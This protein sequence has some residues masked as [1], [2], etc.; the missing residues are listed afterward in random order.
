MPDEPRSQPEPARRAPPTTPGE[1]IA[2]NRVAWPT[3]IGTLGF[4]LALLSG[5]SSIWG[6]IESVLGYDKWYAGPNPGDVV[7]ARQVFGGSLAVLK[8][9]LAFYLLFAA[10]GVHCRHKAGAAQI[11]RWGWMAMALG[12]LSVTF[13]G[14]RHHA[15][16]Q[17]AGIPGALTVMLVVTVLTNALFAFGPP[18][19]VLWWMRRRSVMKEVASWK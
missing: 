12:V 1:I 7:I 3:V 17:G 19:F 2:P 5:L 13:D 6:V 10:I 9:L 4:V 16:L 15:F 14:V 8:F 11:V 18:M